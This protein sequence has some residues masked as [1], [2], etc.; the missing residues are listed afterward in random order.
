M[1]HV[2]H[3]ERYDARHYKGRKKHVL[4]REIL[5]QLLVDTI[6]ID[7]AEHIGDKLVI[8]GILGA[9]VSFIALV[10]LNGLGRM[11]MYSPIDFYIFAFF[12]VIMLIGF[13]AFILPSDYYKLTRCNRCSHDFAYKEDCAPDVREITTKN[14]TT[15]R[16]TTRT[17]RCSYCGDLKKV[18]ETLKMD[19]ISTADMV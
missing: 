3:R 16:Y 15:T 13:I 14:G 6:G 4:M 19:P 1:D 11:F 12:I 10:I 9:I 18:R 8:I 17:Y 5:A 2:K 7:K